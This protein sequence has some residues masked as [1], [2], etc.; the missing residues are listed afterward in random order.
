[1]TQRRRTAKEALNT[2]R[3][4][5]LMDKD[6]YQKVKMACVKSG[7]SFTHFIEEACKLKLES[8]S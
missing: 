4:S 3:T 6:S 5:I 7:K 1:M 8:K 2:V